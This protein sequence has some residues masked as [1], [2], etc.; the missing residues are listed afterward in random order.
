MEQQHN[1][2]NC[3]YLILK[4]RCLLRNYRIGPLKIGR[5]IHIQV[6]THIQWTFWVRHAEERKNAIFEWR[7]VFWIV[8]GYEKT[9]LW[10]IY[11]CRNG[12]TLWRVMEIQLESDKL[13]NSY[14]CVSVAQNCSLFLFLELC[15]FLV[16]NVLPNHKSFTKTY[17]FPCSYF[18]LFLFS[19]MAL[20]KKPFIHLLEELL[21]FFL[22]S[23]KI[24]ISPSLRGIQP[25]VLLGRVYFFLWFLQSLFFDS[26]NR[27]LALQNWFG[28]FSFLSGLCFDLFCWSF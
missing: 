19:L 23:N 22:P 16:F 4:W 25:G 26:F 15:Y 13:I 8:Q 7:L 2:R 17:L 21:F 18:L 6:R 3:F 10:A 11:L 28:Y 12:R 9:W 20:L 14:S 5:I 27:T 1:R 24:N